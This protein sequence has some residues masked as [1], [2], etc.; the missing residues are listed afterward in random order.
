[1]KEKP[2]KLLLV[3]DEDDSRRSSARWLQ[4]K[5]HDVTDVCGGAEAMSFLERESFDVGVF[6]MNMPGM[7]GLELLQRVREEKNEIEVI[8]LT[9]QGTVE[10]AVMAMKMGACDFLS[11]PCSLGDLEH[12][13]FMAQERRE[14]KKK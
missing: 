1:M 2:I 14:L 7:S 3:D 9:G 13:C 12:H 6:D 5:G 11:K 8:M 4:R 10:T